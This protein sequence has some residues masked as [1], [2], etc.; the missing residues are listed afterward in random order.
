MDV[1]DDAIIFQGWHRRILQLLCMERR[2]KSLV[3][4]NLPE[5]D[6]WDIS[7]LTRHSHLQC[8]LGVCLGQSVRK[9]GSSWQDGQRRM[10]RRAS[11]IHLQN[12][13]VKIGID[14]GKAVLT[15]HVHGVLV[16]FPFEIIDYFDNHDDKI[17][18]KCR[19]RGYK[20][21]KLGWCHLLQRIEVFEFRV[22]LDFHYS[23]PNGELLLRRWSKW[24]GNS[25]Y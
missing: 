2:Q 5:D 11:I 15:R 13:N 4:A 19:L 8:C 3:D 16:W 21:L 12:C 10:H 14:N 6:E 25:S 9:F 22:M 1:T 24:K 23:I 17:E 20:Q 18:K 7:C